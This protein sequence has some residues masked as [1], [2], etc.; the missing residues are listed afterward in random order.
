MCVTTIL[1]PDFPNMARSCREHLPM[2]ET[3]FV[4]SCDSD[5]IKKSFLAKHDEIAKAK[6]YFQRISFDIHPL[7][8]KSEL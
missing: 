4:L 3:G 7:E 6:L 8:T 2:S 5:V 1:T